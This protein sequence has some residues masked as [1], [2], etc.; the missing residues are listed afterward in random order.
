MGGCKFEFSIEND[1][2]YLYQMIEAYRYSPDSLGSKREL[3]AEEL[4]P[5]ADI[6][7][8]RE[9]RPGSWPFNDPYVQTAA[10][11]V[12]QFI[13]RIKGMD[14]KREFL[15]VAENAEIALD[16]SLHQEPRD[17]PTVVIVHGLVASGNSPFPVGIA[18]NAIHHG[19][20]AVRVNL[21][22]AGDTGLRSQTFYHA[23]LS[24]DIK[25]VLEELNNKG[26]ARKLYIAAVSL[27]G[28]M[29][30]KAVGEM[31]Q[32]AKGKI[33]GVGLMSSVVNMEDYRQNI[34][35]PYQ[36]FIVRS[37]KD[38]VKR[39][40]K[41]DPENWDI[42]IL[43]GIKRISDLESKIQV[44]EGPLR[45]GFTD[46]QDYYQKASALPYVSK[47]AVPTFIIHAEDDP[48]VSAFPLRSKEFFSN[49]NI[50]VMLTKHGGHGGF[51]NF[52]GIGEDLDRHWAQ[53]RVIEFF[54]LLEDRRNL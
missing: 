54:R 42:S 22:S 36:W 53:N 20:N 39:K 13:E 41:A 44:G 37:M 24:E 28:N 33:G 17:H 32:E 15:R 3:L 12:P 45:W 40:A 48:V 25:K 49:P 29:V 11:V 9:F 19:F 8:S 52:G 35:F 16:Y 47:I 2:E 34:K 38:A 5:I 4:A 6:L 10:G 46:L 43:K 1:I 51:V 18:N 21:R 27:G 30:L 31:G 7:T 50:I 26:L 23:G 14:F